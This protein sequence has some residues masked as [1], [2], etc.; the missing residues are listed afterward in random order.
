[1]YRRAGIL[2]RLLA[3]GPGER[4]QAVHTLNAALGAA[5]AALALGAEVIRFLRDRRDQRRSQASEEAED[6]S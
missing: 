6:E 1:M 2:A 3:Q 4:D 5:A